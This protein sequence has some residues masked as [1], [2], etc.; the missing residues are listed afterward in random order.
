MKKEF[1]LIG[2]FIL[3]IVIGLF[4]MNM[5]ERRRPVR[6]DRTPQ[7]E[8]TSRTESTPQTG[9]TGTGLANPA[10]V[11]CTEKGGTL[12]IQKRGDGG[13]YGLCSFED[14]MACEEWALMRG[15]C[16]VGGIKTTGYDNLQQSYCAWIGG[17]TLAEENA[18]CTLP[19]GKICPVD[20]LYNGQCAA[21]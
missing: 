15:E 18:Q 11:N 7:T 1:L 6:E 17:E 19:N 16:P 20:A 3:V 9:N 2:G 21:N 4:V 8:E 13:E 5:E 10:S 14:N 12:S